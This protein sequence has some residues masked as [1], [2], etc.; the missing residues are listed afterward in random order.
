MQK[1]VLDV[2][3]R[4][5]TGRGA[6]RRLRAEGKIPASIYGQGNARSITV[7]A[8]DFRDLN[9]KIGGGAALL[10][11]KDEEGEMSLCLVQDIQQHAYKGRID[12]I[13]FQEVERGHAFKTKVPVHLKGESDCVGVKNEGG[14]L[15]QK[16]HEIDIRCRPSKLPDSIIVDVSGLTVGGTIQICDLPEVDGVE[17]L[18]EENLVI[19][20]IQQPTVFVDS[21]QAVE[22][23]SSEDI[24]SEDLT[25]DSEETSDGGSEN[26]SEN[27]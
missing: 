1:Y 5:T 18:G 25:R 22:E 20:S 4:K 7:S 8:V 23:V 12:H 16:S 10:E 6:A 14:V 9:R 11:L 3:S 19:V 15:D 24:S 2:S 17:Y 27:K 13:D 21:A 26:E